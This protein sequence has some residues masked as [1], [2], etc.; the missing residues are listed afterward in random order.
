M[1]QNLIF[2]KA[3]VE[4]AKQSYG[5]IKGRTNVQSSAIN[6]LCNGVEKYILKPFKQ[7]VYIFDLKQKPIFNKLEQIRQ[8]KIEE[9]AMG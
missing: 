7:L 1:L 2:T 3:S 4:V 9:F 5:N 8:S 6:S